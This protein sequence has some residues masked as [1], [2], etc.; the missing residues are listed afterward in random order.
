[1]IEAA[2]LNKF[3]SLEAKIKANNDKHLT[4]F[5]M[6]KVDIAILTTISAMCFTLCEQAI[7]YKVGDENGDNKS[8]GY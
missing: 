2:F 8:L 1:M 4:N 6:I 5:A 3:Q 7:K